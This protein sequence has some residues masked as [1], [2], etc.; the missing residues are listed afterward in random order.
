MAFWFILHDKN[1]CISV[2]IKTPHWWSLPVI[3]KTVHERGHRT[4]PTLQQFNPV[5]WPRTTGESKQLFSC[6]SAHFA[7]TYLSRILPSARILCVPHKPLQSECSKSAFIKQFLET[8][9]PLIPTLLDT[10]RFHEKSL[11]SQKHFRSLITTRRA[12]TESSA[13]MSDFRSFLWNLT[14]CIHPYFAVVSASRGYFAPGVSR[15]E[16]PFRSVAVY[17]DC[18]STV[19][20]S[21]SFQNSC[22][23]IS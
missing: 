19:R 5:R 13:V 22:T 17:A 14:D 12:A 11:L 18:V 9:K 3:S 4:L 6:K 8:C 2:V 21:Y 16:T 23:I 10:Q 15:R 1:I 20:I 7:F